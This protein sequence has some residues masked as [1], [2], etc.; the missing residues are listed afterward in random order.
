MERNA[1]HRPMF[2][3]LGSLVVATGLM[4]SVAAQTVTY[5]HTDALGSVVAESDASGNVIKRYDY[6]PYGAVVDGQATDGPG[7]TGHVSDSATGLSYMQQRYMEPQLGIFLSVDPISA[8]GM[9]GAN[10]NRYWY[11]NWNPYRFVDPDGREG[12]ERRDWRTIEAKSPGSAVQM[13]TTANG[14]PSRAD[15]QSRPVASSN[16]NDYDQKDPTYHEYNIR[17]SAL[18]RLGPGCSVASLAAMVDVDS[19]PKFG[20]VKQGPNIL[21]LNN[22]IVHQSFY[23]SDG[24]YYMINVT[25]SAHDFHAGAVVSRLYSGGGYVNLQTSG[26]GYSSGQFA[27]VLNYAAGY[28]YFGLWHMGV[29]GNAK[30]MS[31]QNGSVK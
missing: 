28:S 3:L 27:R 2:K 8:D 4:D 1:M 7:Y 15:M 20:S 10:F 18:C 22:P 12:K 5:I 14:S 6:E 29:V 24:S 16:P 21:H 30:V 19:A 26:F 31:G 23:A 9:N 17:P 11:A 25:T 13:L